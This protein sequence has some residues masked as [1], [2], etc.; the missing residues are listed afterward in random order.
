MGIHTVLYSRQDYKELM[1]LLIRACM[2][3]LLWA[4][5]V[6][7]NTATFFSLEWTRAE[8]EDAEIIVP[9]QSTENGF[10]YIIIRSPYTPYSIYL[11]GT[12]FRSREGRA[13]FQRLTLMT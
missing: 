8:R 6:A 10:G 4:L 11:R 2:L 9:V 5:A 3:R 12:T 1:L 13:E 7:N